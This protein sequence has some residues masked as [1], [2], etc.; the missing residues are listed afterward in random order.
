MVPFLVQRVLCRITAR[1]SHYVLLREKP[2]IICMYYFVS[3]N[4]IISIL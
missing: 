3:L 4:I 2:F 1:E